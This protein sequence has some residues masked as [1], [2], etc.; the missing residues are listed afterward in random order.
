MVPSFPPNDD[1]Y[2]CNESEG[3]IGYSADNN[4]NNINIDKSLYSHSA[5]LVPR[6]LCSFEY[7]A[8]SAQRL[9]ASAIIIYGSLSS[10]NGLNYTNS[11]SASENSNIDD[12]EEK[13][14]LGNRP[15]QG[16]RLF[17]HTVLLKLVCTNSVQL[18]IIFTK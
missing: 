13:E 6:G 8:L 12:E 2:L 14:V 10:R 11:S 4:N 3:T 16:G 7:K 18:M 1:L 15:V 5:L 17:K 9:G